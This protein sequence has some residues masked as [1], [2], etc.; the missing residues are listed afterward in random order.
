MGTIIGAGSEGVSSITNLF[1]QARIS[2]MASGTL[3]FCADHI[4]TPF[5]KGVKSSLGV[6]FVVVPVTLHKPLKPG[7]KHFNYV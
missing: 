1:V 4:N 7:K 5:E 2:R 6:F 3:F